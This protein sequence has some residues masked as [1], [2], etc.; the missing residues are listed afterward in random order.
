MNYVKCEEESDKWDKAWWMLNETGKFTVG[1]AWDNIRQKDEI[2]QN[3]KTLWMKGVPFK[4]SFFLRRLWMERLP[5]AK[6]LIR[7][8]MADSVICCCCDEGTQ[9]TI[10]H[11][12]MQCRMSNNP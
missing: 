8:N 1:S 9:E 2:Q 7:T 10:N 5:I 12:F 3:F 4:V 11:L 6:I